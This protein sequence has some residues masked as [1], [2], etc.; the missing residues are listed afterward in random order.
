MR[1]KEK[2]GDENADLIIEELGIPDYDRRNMK[3][4]CPFHREDHASFI[5]NKKA[6][7]FHCFGACGRS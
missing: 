1:A 7:S 3:C 4:R 2:L 6:F 5:Y